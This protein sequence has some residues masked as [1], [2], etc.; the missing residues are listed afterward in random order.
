M[1]YLTL[2]SQQVRSRFQNRKRYWKKREF[3]SAKKIKI[4]AVSG[5]MRCLKQTATGST[6]ESIDSMSRPNFL[7]FTEVF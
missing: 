2:V 1:L 6:Y 5:M 4:K 3:G 7:E